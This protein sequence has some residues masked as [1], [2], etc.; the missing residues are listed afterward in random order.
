M[1]SLSWNCQIH[2]GLPVVLDGCLPGIDPRPIAPSWLEPRS[3]GKQ[4]LL[5]SLSQETEKGVFVFDITGDTIA[6]AQ[7]DGNYAVPSA[8]GL[9]DSCSN[10]PER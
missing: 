10:A 2:S 6:C 7:V 5:I 8:G 4:G 9:R 3:P 1:A